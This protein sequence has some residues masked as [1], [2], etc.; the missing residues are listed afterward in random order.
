M[1][2]VSGLL[3]AALGVVALALVRCYDLRERFE[4]VTGPGSL[5]FDPGA[6]ILFG[7]AAFVVFG[8]ASAAWP[9][10]S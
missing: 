9:V 4:E 1:S 7:S 5:K 3:Q 8:L 10:V 6:A 2:V